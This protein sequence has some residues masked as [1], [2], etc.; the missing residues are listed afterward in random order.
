MET[1]DVE[2]EKQQNNPGEKARGTAKL[3]VNSDTEIRNMK[4]FGFRN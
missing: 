1:I 4:F 3:V 2:L